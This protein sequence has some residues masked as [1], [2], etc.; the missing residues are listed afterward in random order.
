M[1]ERVRGERSEG[2]TQELLVRRSNYKF[3]SVAFF[4]M[5]KDSTSLENMC[6]SEIFILFTAAS[7]RNLL[8]FGKWFSEKPESLATGT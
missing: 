7:S 1:H 8:D 2:K 4:Q 5:I 3:S 6:S